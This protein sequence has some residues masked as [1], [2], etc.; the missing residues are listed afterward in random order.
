MAQILDER[1]QIES[2]LAEGGQAE[3]FIVRDLQSNGARAVLKRLK[4]PNR[5]PRFVQEVQAISTLDH[6]HVLR[7][8]AA[9]VD[10]KRPYLVSELCER[11]SLEDQK[12]AV[13]T[14]TVDE[15]LAMFL[16]ICD[17]VAAAH[18]AGVV[19]RDIKPSN[20][21]TRSDGTSVVGDFG[22]CFIQT[23][24]RLTETM[25]A[26]GPRFYM[27]PE[28]ADGFAEQVTTRSDVYSLGKLLYWLF[29]GN[30]F[31]REDH[32]RPVRMLPARHGGNQLL[33]H[34]HQLL[35]RMITFHPG[36]R[37][38][39]ATAVQEKVTEVRELMKHEY[40]TLEHPP[41]RCAYCGSGT[42]KMI[43]TSTD[44]SGVFN[45]GLQGVNTVPHIFVCD[46][47]GHVQMFRPAYSK[48]PHWLGTD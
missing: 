32:R 39:D 41:Q 40:P 46:T 43:A 20:I 30:V 8:L 25:E 7:L 1:W 42:Y 48:N 34:V 4:N 22:I 26:V 45:F 2:K 6:P 5:L 14:R 23:T 24:E 35:D 44:K 37:L 47:C 10:A 27:A 36:D 16:D 12:T 3:T 31:E 29:T 11:G 13:L 9:N 21:F 15:R 19:H 18:R 28:L 33:L 17:G 38:S